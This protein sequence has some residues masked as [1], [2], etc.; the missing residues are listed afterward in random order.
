VQYR[1]PT[2]ATATHGPPRP[3]IDAYIAK[4]KDFAIPILE[5]IRDVVHAACP[6]VEEGL[7][8]SSPHF[9]YRGQM[10]CG[11]AAFKEHAILGFW[12]GP[13]IEGIGPDSARGGT[14]GGNMGRLTSI[15]D[16]PSKKQLTTFVR[17]AMKLNEDGVVVSRPKKGPKPEAKVPT[18]LAAALSKS[19]KAKAAFEK[20]P[21]SHRREYV[22]WIAEAKRDETKAKRVAQAV[23][24]IA[25]GK[26]RNWKYEKA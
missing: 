19:R 9:S 23:E 13:L 5:H 22:E 25:E 18:E 20:F 17:A 3:R 11:M 26:G 21:P 2:P 7:K 12:K 16:L 15:K 4:Q 1:L 24:W 14:A 6:E 8:W 10:M